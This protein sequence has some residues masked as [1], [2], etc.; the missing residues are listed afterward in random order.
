M[1][2]AEAKTAVQD[3]VNDTTTSVSQA[4]QDSIRKLSVFFWLDDEDKSLTTIK[5]QTAYTK[6]AGTLYIYGIKI[7]SQE[8]EEITFDERERFDFQADYGLYRFYQTA[9]QIIFLVAPTTTGAQ[10]TIQRRKVFTVPTADATVLDVPDRL[11]H[12]MIL[13]GVL[14]YWRKLLAKVSNQRDLLPDVAPKEARQ[15]LK[16]MVIQYNDELALVKKHSL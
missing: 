10:I 13:G 1:T 16:E 3:Y 8:Y 4:V 5:D 6:P 14:N 12:L 15:N 2:Y 7:G 9:T 11:L